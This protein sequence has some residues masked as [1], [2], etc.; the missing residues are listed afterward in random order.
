[1]TTIPQIIT[2]A[3]QKGGAGKTTLAIHITTALLQMG[4]KV[5]AIEGSKSLATIL[6][7]SS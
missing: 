3:Q 2:I 4:H 7:V 5:A 6:Q 1:M